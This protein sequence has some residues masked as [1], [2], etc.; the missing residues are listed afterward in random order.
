[1]ALCCN[2]KAKRTRSHNTL[3]EGDSELGC[4]RNGQ[5]LGGEQRITLTL[6]YVFN[7]STTIIWSREVGTLTLGK[8]LISPLQ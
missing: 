2:L 5:A 6:I 1:M 4:V 3:N 7:N 8:A